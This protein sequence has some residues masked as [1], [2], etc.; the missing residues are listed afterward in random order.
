MQGILRH[1][2]IQTTLDLCTQEGSD[3]TGA[4]QGEFLSAVGR[5]LQLTN[6]DVGG[7]VGWIMTSHSPDLSQRVSGFKHLE[8]LQGG[9]SIEPSTNTM[10]EWLNDVFAVILGSPYGVSS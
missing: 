7:V 5:A 3:E 1:S 10:V 4:A 8:A 2:K 6:K 9:L